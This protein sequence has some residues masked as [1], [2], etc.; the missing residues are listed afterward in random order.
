M[1][2]FPHHK[3]LQSLCHCCKVR[4]QF[5]PFNKLLNAKPKC[6]FIFLCN[7]FLSRTVQW[8]F[9]NDKR[10]QLVLCKQIELK[11]YVDYASVSNII[12]VSYDDISQNS[13]HFRHYM[14]CIN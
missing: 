6:C 13:Y 4:I 2:T 3:M 11:S 1:A 10:N 5:V 12:D 14:S 9:M 8:F 7:N